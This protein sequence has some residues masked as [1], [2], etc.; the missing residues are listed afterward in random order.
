MYNS[1]IH[2]IVQ[3]VLSMITREKN[4]VDQITKLR[5]GETMHDNLHGWKF[6][7]IYILHE[8]GTWSHPLN[9]FKTEIYIKHKMFKS[10]KL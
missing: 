8:I 10:I 5:A 2:R 1:H 6:T 7:L 3:R 9:G 4:H